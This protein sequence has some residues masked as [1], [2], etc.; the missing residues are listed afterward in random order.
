MGIGVWTSVIVLKWKDGMHPSV[1]QTN[2]K[3][4]GIQL[5]LEW[6]TWTTIFEWKLVLILNSHITIQV[7]C[8][9]IHCKKKLRFP[10]LISMI[11]EI[12]TS[13]TAEVSR[14]RVFKLKYLK[15]FTYNSF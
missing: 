2:Y 1:L 14:K 10:I 3:Q 4:G 6:N 9:Q 15:E 7:C 11:Q 5:I 8:V 13:K 12:K